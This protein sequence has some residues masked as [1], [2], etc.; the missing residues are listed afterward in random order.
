[1]ES[2]SVLVLSSSGPSAEYHGA[3]LGVFEYLQ[4]YNNIPA[5]RKRQTVAGT[6]PYFLYRDV[7]GDWCVGVELGGSYRYLLNTEQN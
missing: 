5:Y 4:Q 2:G 6:Q 3:R 7:S 1:M